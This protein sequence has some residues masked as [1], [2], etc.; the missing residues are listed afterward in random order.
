MPRVVYCDTQPEILDLASLPGR[1]QRIIGLL[2]RDAAFIGAC[3]I[4]SVEYHWHRQGAQEAIKP[5]LILCL[6]SDGGR[7][8]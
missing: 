1:V 3:D 5:K 6:P 7:Y 4:G 2:V 8:G